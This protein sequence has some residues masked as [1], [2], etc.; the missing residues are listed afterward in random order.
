MGLGPLS[1]GFEIYVSSHGNDGNKGLYVIFSGERFNFPQKNK[2][3][4]L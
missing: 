1:F 2:M 3:L 4:I